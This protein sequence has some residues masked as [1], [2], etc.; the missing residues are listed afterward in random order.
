MFLIINLYSYKIDVT[1]YIRNCLLD[2]KTE[3]FSVPWRDIFAALSSR[4]MFSI[5]N[6]K[7][8]LF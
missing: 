6:I 3:N 1:E 2:T 8:I 5:D 4:K 7:M